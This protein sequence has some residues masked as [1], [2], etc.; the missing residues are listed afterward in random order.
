MVGRA[1]GRAPGRR[2]RNVAEREAPGTAGGGQSGDSKLPLTVEKRPWGCG[3]LNVG[4]DVRHGSPESSGTRQSHKFHVYRYAAQPGLRVCATHPKVHVPPLVQTKM[5]QADVLHA[6]TGH[7]G[8]IGLSSNT[9]PTVSLLGRG[10]G[11]RTSLGTA[12]EA[13]DRSSESESSIACR[14]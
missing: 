11:F 5:T 12:V 6:A 13:L 1:H 4:R 2:K 7:T 10:T 3:D 14:K 9:P 8:R